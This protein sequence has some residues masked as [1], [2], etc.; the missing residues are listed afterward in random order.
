ME[1]FRR[2]GLSWWTL[3]LC[4]IIGPVLG[5]GVYTFWYAE[6]AS[7][8]SSDPK[9]CVNCHIMRSAD[10]PIGCQDSMFRF[11]CEPPNC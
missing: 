11:A 9:S 6:G 10:C 4:A 8:F 3:L 7:Y 1:R 2:L 5:L